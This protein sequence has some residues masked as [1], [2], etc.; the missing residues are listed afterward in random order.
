MTAG[1]G[2]STYQEEQQHGLNTWVEDNIPLAS[3]S[4]AP[5]PASSIQNFEP[6]WSVLG[7]SLNT[8]TGVVTYPENK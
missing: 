7:G 3:H 8:A 6:A 4:P 2:G 1:I 5:E